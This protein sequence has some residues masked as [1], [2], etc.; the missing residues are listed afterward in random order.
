MFGLPLF[1]SPGLVAGAGKLGLFSV[2]GGA[3]AGG[4]LGTVTF[5]PDGTAASPFLA[6][7][8]GV[9]AANADALSIVMAANS[10]LDTRGIFFLLLRR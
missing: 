6:E 5:D 9:S 4:L 8:S 7:G 3:P 1:S 2:T 10:K